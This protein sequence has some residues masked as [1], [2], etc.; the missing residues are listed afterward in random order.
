[1]TPDMERAG[2]V[3]RRRRFGL[4]GSVSEILDP[5]DDNP[6]RCRRLV[7]PHCKWI[8]LACALL[9]LIGCAAGT[10]S[11]APQKRKPRSRVQSPKTPA[12]P[13]IDYGN[14]SHTTHVVTQKLACNSC[15]KVPSKNWNVVRKGDAAFQ[16]VADFPEHSSCLS[17]HRA[18]F[19]ARE[20]PAPA[21]CANC[22]IAVTPRDTARW[23]FPSLGDL[24]DPKLKRREFTSEFGVGFPHDK[25]IDVVGLNLVPFKGGQSAAVPG[26]RLTLS[27]AQI[28]NVSYQ[29]KKAGPPKSCPVCHETYQ[30]QG[31]S[32]EE[33]IVKPPKD[34]G[35]N[36]WLKKGTFKT[37]PTSHTICF[38]C[39]NADS[40]I[41]PE[42]KNCETCHKLAQV[43]PAKTD[44]D[45]K[46]APAM[47]ADPLMLARWSRRQ[48]AGA[49]RHEGGMHPD[50]S[51]MDCH[52]VATSTFSTVDPKTMKIAVKS[53]G[54]ADGC[55]I[56]QTLDDGGALNFEVDARKKN[57]NFVCTKCH[58]AFR[59][60]AV[61]E[62]HAHAI[63]TPKPK[64]S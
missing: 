33:Y 9:F 53:C 11:A 12:K 18:Q 57:P 4:T 46:L 58:V 61:P 19:F 36:F 56:T 50:L 30:P 63:P 26:S 64:T 60:D 55:H 54:G 41:A 32:S 38:T 42:P 37:I 2:R 43:T 48:S 29:D 15:H 6:K 27:G 20:R 14:F 1:M 3:V 62:N 39:H 59:K 34:I 31:K 13:K 24:T 17:C 22:H 8:A 35:D 5:R 52:N 45:A 21:I 51:C 28:A 23:L 25:H 47:G 40:G 16:D 7:L 49:F 10:S 44:F